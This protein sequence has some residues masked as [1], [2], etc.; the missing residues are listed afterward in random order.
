MVAQALNHPGG[1]L[2]E[3][4]MK[5]ILVGT[6]LQ[7]NLFLIIR[8]NWTRIPRA[9]DTLHATSNKHGKSTIQPTYPGIWVY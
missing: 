3:R 2:V 7:G 9:D 6:Q 1:H 5:R 8:F 4:K